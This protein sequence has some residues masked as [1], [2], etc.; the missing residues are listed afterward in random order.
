MIKKT[1]R[2]M[3]KAFFLLIAASALLAGCASN[4]VSL[5]SL[6]PMAITGVEGN[7]VIHRMDDNG[8]VNEDEDGVLTTMLNKTLKGDDPE[9]SSAQNRVDY[10]EECLRLLLEDIGGVS[11]VDRDSV[12]QNKTYKSAKTNLLGF[13]STNRVATGYESDRLTIGAK[14]SRILMKELGASSLLSAEFEFDK[15]VE[16][17]QVSAV[18][19]MTVRVFDTSG[20][21]IVNKEYTAES[22]DKIDLYGGDY[23][24][25]A[26]VELFKPTTE[27]VIRNFI[28]EY[29]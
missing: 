21:S 16:K 11:V 14:K 13:M 18:V 26:F 22:I 20:R 10:A 7:L 29:L 2:G 23:D 3:K 28:M 8:E 9:V 19:K 12:T 17:K 15:R 6:S 24:K 1:G 4:K 25:K 27:T 5:D